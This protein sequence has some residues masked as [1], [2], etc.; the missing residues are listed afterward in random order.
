MSVV[1]LLEMVFIFLQAYIYTHPKLKAMTFISQL[2]ILFKQ[3]RKP[4]GSIRVVKWVNISI[5]E[6]TIEICGMC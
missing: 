5:P 1:S 6:I 3:L 4:K 2:L